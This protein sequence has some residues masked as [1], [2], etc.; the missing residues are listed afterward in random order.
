MIRP[1]ARWQLGQRATTITSSSVSARTTQKA[2]G[3]NTYRI[4]RIADPRSR[5]ACAWF[6]IEGSNP[7]GDRWHVATCDTREE[8]REMLK[9]IRQ[10]VKAK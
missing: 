5:G 8:A 2:S 6:E 7:A 10:Q 3:M 1:I 4:I 9:A